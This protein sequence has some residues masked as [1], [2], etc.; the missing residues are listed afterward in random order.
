VSHELPLSLASKYVYNRSEAWKFY[1]AGFA[2]SKKPENREA[3]HNER[4]LVRLLASWCNSF[5][6]TSHTAYSRVWRFGVAITPQTYT[7]PVA[8]ANKWAFNRGC[9]A[10][11]IP[12]FLENAFRN[13]LRGRVMG[14]FSVSRLVVARL[15]LLTSGVE[16]WFISALPEMYQT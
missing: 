9:A 10:K 2:V 4:F 5:L 8:W 11:T 6:V 12:A 16:L 1:D 7:A 3:F 13:V 14:K 15:P